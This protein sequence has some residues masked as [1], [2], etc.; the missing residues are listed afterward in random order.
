M[1]IE[2]LKDFKIESKCDLA[3]VHNITKTNAPTIS[4]YKTQK[5]YVKAKMK[6]DKLIAKPILKT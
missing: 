6:E 2:K 5:S 3:L 4:N 1:D